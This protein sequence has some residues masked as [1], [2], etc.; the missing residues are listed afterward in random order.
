MKKIFLVLL[1]FSIIKV[2]A[3]ENNYFEI[4]IPENYTL[5]NETVNSYKWE[6]DKNYIAIS[7]TSYNNLSIKNF[8]DEDIQKQKENIEN[9]INEELS[10]YDIKANITSIKKDNKD[11]LYYLEYELYL[12][13]K[14]VL[15]F[16][17]Y[18]KGRMY[19]KNSSL[20]TLILNSDKEII[21]D[22][23]NNLVDSF[24]IK[25]FL[26]VS[27]FKSHLILIVFIGIIAGIIGYFISLKNKK[28]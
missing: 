11:D 15:G 13:S 8:N 27:T 5:T 21:N 12:P 26:S 10:N 14:K 20:F 4:N 9:R 23:Y 6:K 7:Y 24:I 18:Q 25:D 22:E 3:Y 2:Y 17:T 16:D 19:S 28:Q 1:L